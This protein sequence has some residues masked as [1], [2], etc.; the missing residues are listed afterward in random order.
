M[1]WG[2]PFWIYA[3]VVVV[4][5]VVLAIPSVDGAVTKALLMPALLVSV[6]LVAGVTG[7]LRGRR[8]WWGVGLLGVGIAA[9]FLGDIL[10]GES[11]V[12]GLAC[13]AAAHI[14]YIAVFN[15]P[16]RERRI[17]WWSLGY[18][19]ALALLVAVLW[20]HLGELR[21]VVLGYGIVLA[22]TAM[23]SARVNAIAAWG[24]GLFLA[25]DAL[26]AFR[27]FF[28]DFRIAFPDPWQDLAIMACY[29]AGEGLIALG[30][31]RRLAAVRG[32]GAEDAIPA[33][34]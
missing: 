19:A 8:A 31:L 12:I 27:L 14:V 26:L 2:W 4:H 16:A 9:S 1:R 6:L 24:G 17:P 33:M 28:P 5:L 7:R 23:T 15:G 32:R 18:A 3:A 20:P 30:V 34:R 25:S 13:F 10:L 22:L 29:C 21:L 11:F